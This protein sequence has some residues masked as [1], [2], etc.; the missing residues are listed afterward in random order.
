MLKH[1]ACLFWAFVLCI[2]A[3][4]VSVGVVLARLMLH[5]HLFL[6]VIFA[7]VA[8]VAL[9]AAYGVKRLFIYYDTPKEG[10]DF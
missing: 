4:G 6:T 9:L 3:A 8:V 7:V 1:Y 10:R 5:K 2:D